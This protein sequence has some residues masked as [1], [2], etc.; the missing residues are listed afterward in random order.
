MARDDLRSLA[1]GG[2]VQL[3]LRARLLGIR[4]L[5]V[6]G[7]VTLTPTD[8]VDALVHARVGTR[9]IV[10]SVP[11]RV[12]PARSAPSN[13]IAPPEP[14]PNGSGLA[15]SAQRLDDVARRLELLRSPG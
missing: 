8:T 2:V 11:G 5:V 1:G 13:A 9:V 14:G 4:L 12:L 10:P 6:D 3:R 7:T 15:R